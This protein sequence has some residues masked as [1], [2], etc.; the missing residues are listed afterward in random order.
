MITG[1]HAIMFSRDAEAV[2]T[3]LRDVLALPSVDAGGG[4]PI[5]AL[6]PAELAA[7]PTSSESHHELYLI[8]DD[9][10]TTVAELKRKGVEFTT[11]VV[12]AGWGVVTRLR[13]PDGGELTLYEPK[14]PRPLPSDD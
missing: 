1:V 8:C 6:P 12:D 14:H 3:F 2:R 5:F 11:E 7:H 13:V 10:N 9:I 4:W